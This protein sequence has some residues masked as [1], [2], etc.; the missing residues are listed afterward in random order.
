MIT[1]R[2]LWQWARRNHSD[3][4]LLTPWLLAVRAVL[5]PIQFLRWRANLSEGYQPSSDTWMINGVRYSARMFHYIAEAQGE[6]FR[7]T[8]DGET[9]SLERLD[10]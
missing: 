8:R 2:R 3:G 10:P 1:R 9:V 6:T 4:D 5:Y 7:I